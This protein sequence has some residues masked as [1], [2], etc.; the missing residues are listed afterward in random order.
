ACGSLGDSLVRDV[1]AD[2]LSVTNTRSDGSKGSP[3]SPR[4]NSPQPPRFNTN[5]RLLIV[6]LITLLGIN[7]Y[8]GSRATQPASR[9]RVPYSPYFLDQVQAGKVKSITSKGTA[10]QGTFTEKLSY[11][12]SKPST[13]FQTQIP[14]FADNTALSK[15]LQ[16]NDVVVNAQPLDVG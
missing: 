3:S 16:D 1:A 4:G 8:L 2:P 15:L 5:R 6:A 7:F 11:N 14:A 12:G 10:I 13:R 9:V